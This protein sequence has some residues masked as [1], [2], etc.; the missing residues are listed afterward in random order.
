MNFFG[1]QKQLECIVDACPLYLHTEWSAYLLVTVFFP[2][3]LTVGMLALGF[4]RSE[5]YVL[6]MG[7]ALS[8]NYALNIGLQHLFRD[9]SRFSDCYA[10]FGGPSFA[11]QQLVMFDTIIMSYPFFFHRPIRLKSI[12]AIRLGIVF[13]LF[14]WVY[15]GANT[16]L[17]LLS[18]AAVGLAYGFAFQ[19]TM[20]G[21]LLPNLA[22]I[23]SWRLCRLFE[24]ED[25]LMNNAYYYYDNSIQ[26]SLQTSP[27]VYIQQ[28]QQ[29]LQH[30]LYSLLNHKLNQHL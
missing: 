9:E 17:E 5:I 14:A 15:I 4:Y 13:T 10:D 19:C 12:V 28:Q 8:S 22:R 24:F 16:M 1:N 3:Y 7:L 30:T 6:L 2:H 20:Y 27:P 26:T 21:V 29:Q 23:L 11:T 18:G 25:T